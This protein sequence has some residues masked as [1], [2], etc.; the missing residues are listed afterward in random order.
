MTWPLIIPGFNL[1]EASPECYCSSQVT[2]HSAHNAHYSILFFPVY[3]GLHQC[4]SQ[5]ICISIRMI[6]FMKHKFWGQVAIF[7]TYRFST[8]NVFL[9]LLC[10]AHW[11]QIYAK[12]NSVAFFA[13]HPGEAFTLIG[14]NSMPKLLQKPYQTLLPPLLLTPENGRH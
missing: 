1:K 5:L 3:I 2:W 4:T 8:N 13:C 6:P 9:Q 10:I 7:G 14:Y 12:D 11:K